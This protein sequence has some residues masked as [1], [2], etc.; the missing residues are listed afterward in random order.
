MNTDCVTHNRDTTTHLDLHV[1]KLNLNFGMNLTLKCEKSLEMLKQ[2][3]F[4][5]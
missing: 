2:N 4:F 5:F 1:G 3:D